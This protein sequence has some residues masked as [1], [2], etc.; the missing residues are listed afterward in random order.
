MMPE[1]LV[2]TTTL[3]SE[4][5]SARLDPPDAKGRYIVC[6]DYGSIGAFVEMRDFLA[7][8]NWYNGEYLPVLCWMPLPKPP[9]LGTPFR[10]KSCLGN[11]PST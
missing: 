7:E 8:G 2:P 3:S 9:A 10:A 4:W 11:T 1:P 5:R 6:A